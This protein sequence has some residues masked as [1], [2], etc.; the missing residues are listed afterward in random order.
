MNKLNW[1]CILFEKS[2]SDCPKTELFVG[3]NV[4][5]EQRRLPGR[6][7]PKQ[8][9]LCH[10]GA[11]GSSQKNPEVEMKCSKVG[12]TGAQK[13]K[14]NSLEKQNSRWLEALLIACS[15]SCSP[16]VTCSSCTARNE[17][18]VRVGPARTLLARSLAVSPSPICRANSRVQCVLVFAQP[19][20]A[21]AREKGRQRG[22]LQA[23]CHLLELFLML[24]LSQTFRIIS[25]QRHDS[26]CVFDLHSRSESEFRWNS[27]Q[28]CLRH[29]GIDG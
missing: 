21:S 11:L 16:L 8:D 29:T 3:W 17:E 7:G 1:L 22:L 2:V 5:C 19:S 14:W 27:H 10:L 18:S 25:T 15:P 26:Y 6:T 20:G 24:L 13:P 23:T 9:V 28:R 12:H 4:C